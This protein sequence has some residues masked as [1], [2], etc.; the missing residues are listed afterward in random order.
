MPILDITPTITSDTSH[1][2]TQPTLD[3]VL[4]Q[5]DYYKNKRTN[6]WCMDLFDNL[7]QPL[8]LGIGLRAGIDLLWPYRSLEVPAGVLFVAP[9]GTGL[10][11]PSL[12]AFENG[13]A[14][15]YYI[16]EAEVGTY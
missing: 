3:N 6:L 11:D 4:F 7:S 8:V 2:V 1:I 13:L 12:T 16:P 10:V 15:I 9:Q 5:I 14:S